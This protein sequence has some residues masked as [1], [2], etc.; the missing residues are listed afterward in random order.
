[1]PCGVV[2]IEISCDD[3]VWMVK[4][5]IELGYGVGVIYYCVVGYRGKVTVCYV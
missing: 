3:I 2:S 4:E 5:L 1:M